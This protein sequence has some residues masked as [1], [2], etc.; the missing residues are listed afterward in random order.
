MYA[1]E[2]GITWSQLAQMLECRLK[3]IFC[4]ELY[5]YLICTRLPVNWEAYL[6]VGEDICTCSIGTSMCTCSNVFK[7]VTWKTVR[8]ST[9]TWSVLAQLSPEKHIRWLV[10]ILVA[11]REPDASCRLDRIGTG[12]LELYLAI[13]VGLLRLGI[14]SSTNSTNKILVWIRC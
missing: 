1:E 11:P 6:L 10:R 2:R 5:L 3:G 9:C 8:I 12:W 14:N 13:G 7:T 4:K